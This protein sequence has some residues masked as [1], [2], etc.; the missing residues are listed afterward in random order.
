MANLVCVHECRMVCN[1]IF[2]THTR[3]LAVIHIIQNNITT[4]VFKDIFI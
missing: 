3:Y 4:L 2:D 1:C